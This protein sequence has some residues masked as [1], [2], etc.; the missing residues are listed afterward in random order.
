MKTNG[1][2][3]KS[4]KF[5][6][7]SLVRKY[8]HHLGA[9]FLAGKSLTYFQ[10]NNFIPTNVRQINF[11]FL[12]ASENNNNPQIYANTVVVVCLDSFQVQIS[13]RSHVCSLA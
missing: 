7:Y 3:W 6:N 11:K 5:L 1:R 8:L 2:I 10:V 9:F 13:M 4:K 12:S